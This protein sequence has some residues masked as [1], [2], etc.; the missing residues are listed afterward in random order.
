MV[1]EQFGLLPDE[2]AARLRPLRAQVRAFLAAELASGGFTWAPEGW[3]RYDAAFSKKIAAQGWIGMTWPKQYG[4]HERSAL[5]RYVV[6]EELL[7]TGAP[8][9][10]HWLADRQFGPLLLAVGTEE[11]KQKFLPRIAAG[12]CFVCLGLSE[13]DTGSDLASI[14]TKAERVAGGWRINGTKIWASYAHSAHFMNIFARTSPPADGSR[15]D[16]LT[17]F[18]I[19]LS[20]PGITVRPIINLA[21]EH[22]FNEVVFE[23]A[24][25]ADDMVLGQVGKGWGQVS[26]ELVYERSGPD[27][28]LGSFAVLSAVLDEIGTVPAQ[29][30]AEKFGRLVAHLWTL[31]RMSFSIAYQ[32]G[33][34]ESPAI[35][36]ALLKDLGNQFDQDVP[37][38]A[39]EIVPAS[40]RGQPSG[41]R[42]E[43]VLRRLQL[44]APSFTLRGGTKE[45][46]RGITARGLGLR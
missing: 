17:Q 45:I 15:H 21:G 19:D 6:T 10:A 42:F 13:P 34:G 5:E 35:E 3:E 28:W 23:D 16:G 18:L 37:Q 32:L 9:R 24:F 29:R 20:S 7:V 41:A 36:A 1:L 31:H 27:R 40:R 2:T 43:A 4:G 30:E 11:Q 39:R 22:D 12:E 26:G 33:Q 25:V 44:Y 14:R 8:V 38:V 46:M